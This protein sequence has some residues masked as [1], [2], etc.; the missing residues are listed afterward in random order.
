[1]GRKIDEDPLTRV[2][3]RVAYLRLVCGL[4]EPFRMLKLKM[5]NLLQKMTQLERAEKKIKNFE[6]ILLI[7]KKEIRRLEDH[8]SVM[9][10]EFIEAQRKRESDGELSA[11]MVTLEFIKKSIGGLKKQ[12]SDVDKNLTKTEEKRDELKTNFIF[13]K[14]KMQ[15]MK[16]HI[17]NILIDLWNE[18]KKDE[19]YNEFINLH[20]LEA[21]GFIDFLENNSRMDIMS[22]ILH[23]E[24][25]H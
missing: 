17:H 2:W 22:F 11:Y 24:Y 18:E 6:K 5:F 20:F 12:R 23:R 7:L 15:R 4:S 14:K 21:D 9:E 25:G 19:F 10:D 3:F 8:E 13:F 16:K 1:M